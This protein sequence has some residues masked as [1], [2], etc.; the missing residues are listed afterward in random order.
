MTTTPE[1]KQPK[2][3]AASSENAKS[4]PNTPNVPL[5]PPAKKLPLPS[6]LSERQAPGTKVDVKPP[7][8]KDNTASSFGS[9]KPG[10]GFTAAKPVKG[11]LAAAERKS[12]KS[13]A[14]ATR[15]S[16]LK[17]LGTANKTN[18]G[19]ALPGAASS[20]GENGSRLAAKAGDL[21]SL[22]G[23]ESAMMMQTHT[24]VDKPAADDETLSAEADRA[25]RPRTEPFQ[26]LKRP[27]TPPTHSIL[28]HTALSKAAQAVQGEEKLPKLPPT[29]AHRAERTSGEHRDLRPPSG[30]LSEPGKSAGVGKVLLPPALP[31][32]ALHA[33]QE[34][35]P[36]QRSSEQDAILNTMLAGKPYAD[37][38]KTHFSHPQTVPET[39][40]NY[41]EPQDARNVDLEKTEQ[42]PEALEDVIWAYDD[43]I[44]HARTRDGV[45]ECTIQLAIARILEHSGHEKLAYVRYLK[46][47]E[48]NS[49]SR[50]AVHELRRIARAYDKQK[51]VLTLLRSELDIN[52]PKTEQSILLEEYARI[53]AC[54][55]SHAD[56][57]V[58]SLNRAISLAPMRVAPQHLL[59][60]HLILQRQWDD[61]QAA[62]EKL[63]SLTNDSAERAAFYLLQAEILNHCLNQPQAAI[64]KYIQAFKETPGS[65][66][67]FNILASLLIQQ[68]SWQFAHGIVQTYADSTQ[69]R[70]FCQ[71]THIL[72]GAI[73]I[74]KLGELQ[75]A[76][77]S[78]EKA[79]SH[80]PSDPLALELLADNLFNNVT[81][82]QMLDKVLLK[83]AN[84]SLVP[85]ERVDYA[86][87]RAINLNENGRDAN[88]AIDVLQQALEEAPQNN[89]LFELLHQ[90]LFDNERY[91]EVLS[92]VWRTGEQEEAE[93]AAARYTE[94]GCHYY[95]R[96]LNYEEAEKCFRKALTFS[97]GQ[98]TA[99]EYL[100]QILRARGDFQD[101]VRIYRARLAVT[102][103]ACTRASLLHTVATLYDH[104]LNQHDDAIICYQQY[105]EIFPDD[106]QVIHCLERLYT[107][108]QNWM[109][110]LDMLAFER[111]TAQSPLERCNILI[112]TASICIY[113]LGKWQY[114]IDLLHEA[115]KE[116]PKNH[117]AYRM[118]RLLLM[119][120]KRWSELVN[121]YN[122]IIRLQTS[123]TEKIS[124]LCEM[125][126]ICDRKLRDNTAA[127]ACY[128]RVLKLDPTNSLALMRLEMI[129]R[130]TKNVTAYY[131]LILRTSQFFNTPQK[132]RSLYKVALKYIT[133]FG[134][135]DSAIEVLESAASVDPSYPPVSVLLALAYATTRNFDALAA[136]VQSTINQS[137]NQDT[138]CETAFAL[139]SIYIWKH[140]KHAEAVHPLELALALRPDMASARHLLIITQSWLKQH[141]EVASLY[142]EAAQHCRDPKL[143]IGYCK[144]AA[145][146]AHHC[147]QSKTECQVDEV[148]SLRRILELEPEEIIANERLE[149]MEPCRS[150][151]VPFFEKRLKTATNDDENELK[152][153]IAESIYVDRPQD[154]FTLVCEVVEKN[155]THLP[156]IRMAGNIAI[157]R[158][159]SVL[160][161]HFRALE[162]RSLENIGMRIVAWK[163]AATIAL[164]QLGQND[165][166]ASHLKQAFLLAPHRMDLCDDLIKIL[167]QQ[168]DL[169]EIDNILQIH[170]RSI[171]KTNRI[172]RYLQMADL[173]L[174]ALDE[175]AQAAIKLR[176][177]LEIDH[178][179]IEAHR[180][181]A[182]VESSL[183]HWNEARSVLENLIN[184]PDL[185]DDILT[186]S[187]IRLA[188]LYISKLDKP[189]AAI[190]ILQQ[191]L[192][193]APNDE[194][195]LLLLAKTYF[196]E[197]KLDE[198]LAL[199]LRLNDIMPPPKCITPLLH[200]AVVY[201]ILNDQAKLSE[202]MKAAA[203]LVPLDPNILD[204]IQPLIQSFDEPSVIL[205]FVEELLTLQDVPQA[206]RVSIYAFVAYCY[207]G[208]LHMRFEADKYA[209]AAAQIAPQSID[210]QLL[211]AKVFDPKEAMLHAIEAAKI[212]PFS[213]EP[214]KAMHAIASNANRFDMQ[215]RIEQQLL[216]LGDTSL[217]TPTIQNTFVQ[218]HPQRHGAVDDNLLHE[219]GGPEL[220][221]YVTALF[222]LAGQHAQ[223]FVLPPAPAEPLINHPA[224]AALTTE[225]VEL[226]GLSGLDIRLVR[227]TPFIFS[228]D[229]ENPS[230]LVLNATALSLAPDN[231][232][233]FHIASALTHMKLGTMLIRILNPED[234]ARLVSGFV[235][236]ANGTSAQPDVMERLKNFIPRKERRAIIDFVKAHP[237]AHF[238]LDPF[239]LQR[240][241]LNLEA[242]VGLL[243]CTDLNAAISGVFRRKSPNTNIPSQRAVHYARMASILELFQFNISDTLTELRKNLGIFLKMTI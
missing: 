202:T 110:V 54:M 67:V 75:A 218:R 187:R 120:Q 38:R 21:L 145:D 101:I 71:A 88:A 164:T 126:D 45:R 98:R 226:F 5:T 59:A 192:A 171:S 147:A 132:A 170:V 229:V 243:C 178:A 173:Y 144:T 43:E 168:R 167:T 36:V 64:N 116:N 231:E 210:A 184:L 189:R 91:D 102:Q 214:Y 53:A 208:P 90:I 19:M 85:K 119:R 97:P 130:R 115:R 104:C 37:V 62:Y 161:C 52:I 15:I 154:A 18:Q 216:A 30:E 93:N 139:A 103:D 122:D 239:Q 199:Y 157:E 13:T 148:L 238:N 124:T 48:A 137:P 94:L 151:L 169:K 142:L 74:D 131:D 55:P 228:L 207:G 183:R 198:S 224:L 109:G 166:A 1:T 223:I 20:K 225:L 220:N 99:F 141:S 86:I 213:V 22:V 222:K 227:D 203:R 34:A 188:E 127:I 134:R 179:H 117:Q 195:A 2:T 176:Q 16:P 50:T 206:T 221:L 111:D 23:G 29:E 72:A 211:A 204:E 125:G 73:A 69:D 14:S 79:H 138:K 41:E 215:A 83:L 32:K 56:E 149:S 200:M 68:E 49:R 180:K 106:I 217:L 193:D 181:L 162:A 185:P 84:L 153:S 33:S 80:V 235:G 61:A 10:P 6:G 63:P 70:S 242:N 4:V 133:C 57:V 158:N 40:D 60:Q 135:L 128:E 241:L 87:M 159:N 190:P 237:P 65:L 35:E 17:P 9:A 191:I 123:T 112:R 96:V 92:L 39:T 160:A 89:I 194:R 150:N 114:A 28:A 31:A 152:L 240:T 24:D 81:Y 129:Y 47:L 82:W 118:L 155:P 77:Q 46:A 232:K 143:A 156:A 78:F 209:L 234:I 7:Q 107:A 146:I 205:T 219:I 95:D 113:K 197:S 201:K 230:T 11:A 212:S 27:P 51:D 186:E 105:R 76:I 177:V 108:T 8:D 236:L 58:P 163:E 175:P 172:V 233:R 196:D 174:N 12:G 136:L 3:E 42:L 140:N 44:K 121:V 182:D 165:L 100:E 26:P 25:S 66:C